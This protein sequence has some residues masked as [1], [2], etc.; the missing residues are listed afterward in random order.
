MSPLSGYFEVF[1]LQKLSGGSYA[2]RENKR[3]NFLEGKSPEKTQNVAAPVDSSSGVYSIPAA[4]DSAIALEGPRGHPRDHT[5]ASSLG[6]LMPAPMQK[7]AKSEDITKEIGTALSDPLDGRLEGSD[8][9]NST[10][11]E[12]VSV[13]TGSD[14]ISPTDS[15][16]TSHRQKSLSAASSLW[17]RRASFGWRRASHPSTA[18]WNIGMRSERKS[19][20][21]ED[22]QE[23]DGA[24]A[25]R[26]E[27]NQ[28][29]IKL[30]ELFPD[31]KIE[32]FRELLSR[33][34]GSSRLQICVEQLLRYR[35]AWVN[36]RWNNTTSGADGDDGLAPEQASVPVEKQFRSRVYK[37]AV[38]SLLILEFR[39][40]SR[41]TIDD[42]LA[43]H[44]SS[45]THSRPELQDLSKQTWR[46]TI[47]N[48]FTSRRKRNSGYEEHPLIFWPRAPSKGG[49]NDTAGVP[50]LKPSG[51]PELDEE[52]FGLFLE[53]VQSHAQEERELGDRILAEK[54]NEEEAALVG[55][56][57]ECGC[58]F[59]DVTFEQIATCSTGEHIICLQCIQRTVHEA[60]FGQ[61][62]NQ[63]V[64]GGK[65]TIRCISPLHGGACPGTLQPAVVKN[66][67][68]SQRCGAELFRKFETRFATTSLMKSRLQLIHCPFCSY[69]E[70]DSIYHPPPGGVPYTF[71]RREVFIC[72][73][74]CLTFSHLYPLLAVILFILCIPYR[75]RIHSA[76]A[77]S[78]RNICLKKRTQRFTC[79]NPACARSSCI[80]CHKAW[81]DP[82]VCHKTL[83]A[84]LRSTVEAARTA[85]VKRTCP[86][87]G[88]SFVKSSGCNK[89]TCVCGYKMC[90]ICRAALGSPTRGNQRRRRRRRQQQQWNIDAL[91]PHDHDAVANELENDNAQDEESEEE[92][93]HEPGGY[94]HF[95][96]H[97]RATPGT[98]CGEC[99]KCELYADED[100]ELVARRAGEKA[101]KLWRIREGLLKA[102]N[103]YDSSSGDAPHLIDR[104]GADP[105]SFDELTP[106]LNGLENLG[107]QLD[108]ALAGNKELF[109]QDRGMNDISWYLYRG[110]LSGPWSYK[111]QQRLFDSIVEALTQVEEF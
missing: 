96:Q 63:S 111:G 49:G 54:I 56:L 48:I 13:R 35:D 65:S 15:S 45:Y 90:Y 44:N 77:S 16:E 5:E 79:Q 14:E 3:K 60:L 108:N 8:S 99:T 93:Y 85:A 58:C 86:Q 30:S 42:I 38:R 55:A 72:I 80:T 67:I 81:R 19:C 52:L 61:G 100:E 92:D 71:R 91:E 53:P 110:W 94:K 97:F 73:S 59:S 76:F 29:I 82:H 87:C 68:L 23:C 69:A 31:I 26:K 33:F 47:E 34:D 66:A 28:C 39:S 75:A 10:S 89:L 46:T 43:K 51:S 98:S 32:V 102:S 103:G 88:T 7:V 4:A 109:W 36:G 104:A 24:E 6:S 11:K 78:V 1:D 40:L 64:D 18:P 25:E 107:I 27:L 41:N 74:I 12:H 2:S 21:G 37:E 101:E 17:N 22:Q 106:G 95:C 105:E 83:L 9:T 20:Q 62:W 50:S 57:Y 70:V 84:S